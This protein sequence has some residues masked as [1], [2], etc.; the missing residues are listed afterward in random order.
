MFMQRALLFPSDQNQHPLLT[1]TVTV[2]DPQYLNPMEQ[3]NEG[4]FTYLNFSVDM[5]LLNLFQSTKWAFFPK[6]EGR[7][8]LFGSSRFRK[9]IGLICLSRATVNQISGSSDEQKFPFINIEVSFQ[10]QWQMHL[11]PHSTPTANQRG[12]WPLNE[13]IKGRNL[14]SGKGDFVLHGVNF[15]TENDFMHAPAR[16]YKDA[17]SYAEILDNENIQM[18]KSFS[19]IG[20][21]KRK[22]TG[23]TEHCL[24]GILVNLEMRSMPLTFGFIRVRFLP[25]SCS[26][27]QDLVIT[28]CGMMYLLMNNKWHVLAVSYSMDS[29]LI[30]MWVDGEKKEKE[31][32]PCSE[33]K[34]LRP[35]DNVFINQ[36]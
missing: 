34:E 11:Q 29:G 8:S 2:C 26:H 14:V 33:G 23:Q 12:F 31:A 4:I 25:M 28:K 27:H 32:K 20:A 35:A 15:S 17:G 5:P 24:N 1:P 7:W 36:R 3:N 22:V 13:D 10:V 16:F 18:S 30:T 6:S 19:W 9:C 21:V